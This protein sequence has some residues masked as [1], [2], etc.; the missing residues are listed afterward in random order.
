MHRCLS[1]EDI[2]ILDILDILVCKNLDLGS[3]LRIWKT[4]DCTSATL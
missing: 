1:T 4:S 3:Y 2:G